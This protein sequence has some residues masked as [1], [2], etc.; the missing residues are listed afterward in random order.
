MMKLLRTFP[1]FIALFLTLT[2]VRAQTPGTMRIT[3]FMYQDKAGN[4]EFAEFTNV[5][6]TP[7]DMTGWSY[8][9]SHNNP[10]T[11]DLS[12]FGTV[13]PGESVIITQS[14]PTVFRSVW[15]L[16]SSI[17]VISYGSTDNLGRNDVIHLYDN[18][19]NLIDVLAYDDQD[20]TMGGGP[21][22]SGNSAWV[23]A[24]A[25][26][27]GVAVSGWTISASGDA[28]G[29]YA[30]TNGEFGSPGKSGR[31]IVAYT[32]CTPP[33]PN[34]PTIVLD[35]ASTSN[36]LDQGVTTAPTSP[37]FVSGVLND[38]TD[39]A[40][41]LGLFFTVG[42]PNVDVS[43][44]TV[45]ATSSNPTV[46][47]AANLTL[48]GSNASYK[49]LINPAAVGYTTITVTVN[50]GTLTSTYQVLYAASQSASPALHW[51]TGNSDASDAIALDDN[52]MVI[53][54]DEQNMV[55]V[56]NRQKS[57]LPVATFDYNQLNYLHLTDA[58]GTS[59]KEVDVEAATPS[60]STLH[61]GRSYWFGSMSNSSSFEN[62]PDRDRIVALKITGATN[63]PTIAN[64]GFAQNIRQQ[65]I[66]WGDAHS[67]GFTA[68]SAAGVDPK[69]PDGFNIEGAVFAPDNTTLY[70]GFRAPLVPNAT[71]AHAVIAPVL[72]FEDWFDNHQ[73]NP[74][75]FGDPIELDLGG[76]GIRDIIRLTNGVYV[77]AAG[78][79]GDDNNPAI[80]TWTGNASD[81][82]VAQPTFNVT[83]LNVEGLLQVNTAGQPAADQLQV[84]TDNGSTK[85]YGDDIEAKD[86][87][88]NNFK[89]FSSSIVISPIS[90]LPIGYESFTAQRVAANAQLNWTIG[91]TG[92][93]ATFDVLRSTDGTNFSSVHSE[94]G[95]AGQ[96]T[97]TWIDEK[98]PAG[99]LY[100][101]IRTNEPSG[102]QDFSTIRVLDAAGATTN[103]IHAY[104][105][106]STNGTFTLAI[107]ATG[108][109]TVSIYNS[110]G[111][112]IR[113]SAFADNAKDFSTGG[114]AKGLYLLR[115]V[116]PDGSITTEK[117][118]IQ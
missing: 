66:D 101:R 27:S 99:K 3:E 111:L 84:I 78:S 34:A 49:L 95:L 91:I 106:P 18:N 2:A 45:A 117:L 94:P 105:N 76:R 108:L 19:S 112:L 118:T 107:T 44:L 46:V 64:D 77:I 63:N 55:Y 6:A 16:C 28:E 54:D 14:D 30:S 103:S 115:I 80:Y 23:N 40:S 12:A 32:P 21:R 96:K 87:S 67:Y 102:Q 50:N 93:A 5:G 56:F 53:G 83:G 42:D 59:F 71:I 61:P 35:F 9:D 109:K 60:P 20:A 48:T 69:T 97:Y 68:A 81:A 22:T 24:A 26:G 110:A 70:Y 58:S 88:A 72:N 4:G 90:P 114:W 113:Q 51:P 62:K 104:P 43:T 116:L 10:G 38:A 39:P 74:L 75:T 1:L 37:Y 65:L 57:G 17:K 11:V 33:N 79:S 85:F 25:L 31:A 41:T 89:K 47:P 98:I 73:S 36:L 92:T 13:Q 82:P 8:D 29:S 100:Y 86:L 52:F 7:V 15:G